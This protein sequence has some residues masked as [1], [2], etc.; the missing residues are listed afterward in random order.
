VRVASRYATKSIAHRVRSYPFPVGLAA[1]LPP[2][3]RSTPASALLPAGPNGAGVARPY[4]SMTV[5]AIFPTVS[6]RDTCRI[7][8]ACSSPGR[9][10]HAAPPPAALSA[11][12]RDGAP[13]RRFHSKHA[14]PR[15]QGA[16]RAR[17]KIRY[18]VQVRHTTSYLTGRVWPPC[19][20]PESSCLAVFKSHGT[21][22]RSRNPH[23]IPTF[24]SRKKLLVDIR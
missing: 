21:I 4:I 1:I 6:V 20:L 15:V 7:A 5:S 23:Q 17:K 10:A 18:A 3:R 13:P 16:D 8:V 11:S 19:V 9:H 24:L 22:K 2:R 12:H 14:V